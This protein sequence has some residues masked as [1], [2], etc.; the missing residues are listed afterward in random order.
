LSP[1]EAEEPT[2]GR[3]RR[4]ASSL[5]GS[6]RSSYVIFALSLLSGVLGWVGMRRALEVTFEE[7]R[8]HLGVET[9][10]QRSELAI[11][12]TTPV[13]LGLFS[14]VIVL[15]LRLCPTGQIPVETAAWYHNTEATFA[16]CLTLVRQHLWRAQYFVHSAPRPSACPYLGRSLSAY[17][18]TSR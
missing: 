2:G 13:L 11:I 17:S 1:R 6:H 18:M 9:Q 5:M 14:P 7:A 12:R 10:R 8:A 3:F 16:D 4:A 15:A